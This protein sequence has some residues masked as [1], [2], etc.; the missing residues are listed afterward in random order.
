MR[1]EYQTSGNVQEYILGHEY[2]TPPGEGEIYEILSK[3]KW[4]NRH[5]MAFKQIELSTGPN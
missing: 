3:F 1:F 5:A 4:N 2:D